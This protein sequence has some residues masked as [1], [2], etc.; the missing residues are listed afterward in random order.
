MKLD[1]NHTSGMSCF[2]TN[3]V[4]RHEEWISYDQAIIQAARTRL[5]GVRDLV[6]RGLKHTIPN[7]M[8]STVMQYEDVGELTPAERSMDGL[9]R[10]QNDR[11]EF[12]IKYLP[13]PLTHYDYQINDRVL[14]ASRDTGQSLDTTTAGLAGRQI[15]ESL[16]TMLFNGTSQYKYGPSSSI[17]YGYTDFPNRVQYTMA[18]DW[19]LSTTTGEEIVQDVLDMKQAAIDVKRYGP[20]VLYVPT[21]YETRLDGDFKSNS[22]IT[23][24]QRI[25]E[26]SNIEAITV[27]DVLEAGATSGD[28]NNLLLV[29]MTA[30]TVRW[31]NGLPIT[32]REMHNDEFGLV[33][34]FKIMTIQVPQIRADQYN[35]CGIVHATFT[36]A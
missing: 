26:I 6:T 10:G 29:Q 35:S 8:G 24:R 12:G 36:V 1:F 13:L 32:N 4:L 33:H 9:T 18:K 34:R 25:M 7:G 21:R 27:V 20:F 31:V 19:A 22:G 28:V 16:E 23:I 17:I 2:R 30:D 14:Q 3:A 15:A 5:V 11:P